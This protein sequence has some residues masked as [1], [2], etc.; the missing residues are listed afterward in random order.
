MSKNKGCLLTDARQQHTDTLFVSTTTH[1][2]T[3]VNKGLATPRNGPKVQEL[4][5]QMIEAEAGEH[6]LRQL[7]GALPRTLTIGS[8]R[9]DRWWG[10]GGEFGG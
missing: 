5:V 2:Q 6:V 1:S 4:L 8:W 3:L 7:V 9:R 10:M